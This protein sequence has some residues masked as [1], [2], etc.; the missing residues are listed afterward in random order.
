MVDG[1]GALT[2]RSRTALVTGIGGFV[3]GGLAL[4]LLRRGA[5]VVGIVRDSAG[6]RLLGRLGILDGVELVSGSIAEPGI[7]QRAINEYEVD[8]VF[9]L[10]AQAIVGVANRSPL[11]TFES[12]ITGTWQLLEAARL[13]RL[14]RRV[15][16][17]SSDKA[18]GD[19]DVLP[20]TEETPLAGTYPYDASKVCTDVLARCYAVTYDLPIAV[21]RCA[22]IYGPGDLNW[23]RLIPGTVRSVLQGERPIIRSDGT[24]ERDYLYLDDAVDGY[25][26]VADYL[27]AGTGEAFNLGTGV[28][29]S[30]L[31]LVNTILTA[32]GRR[33]LA[34]IIL[35]QGDGEIDRQCLSADKAQRL[36]DWAPLTSLIT[37]LGQTV[38]WYAGH[39]K[40]DAPHVFE[41]VLA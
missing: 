33:D 20:Y 18:Y 28:A 31:S 38:D 19:Q 14:V 37:G 41:K 2:W 12:N 40:L 25:L 6:S 22:N 39:L 34:P 26:R 24:P 1:E 4:E 10:A 13:S 36:L 3:G 15:V 32:A 8:T 21:I 27:P 23:S 17:A 11:S 30:A 35:G 16:V 5:R 7:V 29:V 9:H